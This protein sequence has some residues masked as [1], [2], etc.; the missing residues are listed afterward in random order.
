MGE[1]GIGNDIGDGKKF[2]DEEEFKDWGFGEDQFRVEDLIEEKKED[3]YQGN[4]QEQ[5]SPDTRIDKL[6]DEEWEAMLA[7]FSILQ[8]WPAPP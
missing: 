4:Y 7:K 2:G 3:Q 1:V 6:S 8:N 5:K